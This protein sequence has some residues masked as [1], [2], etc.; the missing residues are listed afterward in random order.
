MSFIFITM[1][2]VLEKK[3]KYNE[4]WRIDNKE[5]VKNY[6]RDT[7]N[8]RAE[9][10]KQ[11]Y[12]KNIENKKQ[13]YKDNK[14][15]ILED[16][17]VYFKKQ[18]HSDS[19]FKLRCCVRAM[20]NNSFKNKRFRKNSK[21]QNILGCSFEEFKQYLE[22]HFESWMNW[23]NKS[24]NIVTEPNTYWDVDHIIPISTAQ[25]EEDVVKLN[26]YT[27]LRPCC[28]YYNRFIKRNSID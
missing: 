2:T 28:A 1:N 12:L 17:K 26:H 20:I 7:K 3:Y 24:N 11:H 4:Q 25:T 9:Y 16:R 23:D 6:Y 21:T 19:L 27:N 15:K 10:Q 14:E 18:Y 5:K 8:K 13:Y 22:L